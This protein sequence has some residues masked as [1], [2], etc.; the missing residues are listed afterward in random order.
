MATV[1]AMCHGC[2]DVHPAGDRRLDE[3]GHLTT[4][5]PACGSPSYET[6]ST[7]ERI[8]KSEG[9][10]IA[11]AVG[12][13]EGVGPDTT[14]NIQAAIS[15]YAELEAASRKQLRAIDG[16]GPVAADGIRDAVRPRIGGFEFGN[17]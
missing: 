17:G 8:V 16:V 7:G 3:D 11:D 10:R 13:V 1:E 4:I 12:D 15:C 9:E 2:D 5:C 6:R 14:E